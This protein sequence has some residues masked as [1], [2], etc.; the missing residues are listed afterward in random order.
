[1][2]KKNGAQSEASQ[3]HIDLPQLPKGWRWATVG[4]LAEADEQPVLTGPFG[5]TLGRADFI[6]KG[7]PLLT[8]G[9]LTEAGVTLDKAF[10]ISNEKADQLS[11]YRVRKGDL[12]FSR[13]A[14]V[15]RAGLVSESLEGSVINYHLM[16]L[17]LESAII[18]P[19]LFIYYVRGSSVVSAY[20]REV[21]HGATR[22]G[23]NTT[24]LLGMPV[25]V[26]PRDAQDRIV[27]RIEELFSDLEAGV[28]ALTRAR[29]NLKRYR[30]SVLKAAVEGALTAEWRTRHPQVEPAS[31]L[32]ERLL[33]ERRRQWEADQLAKFA[34]AGKQPPNN[35]QAKYAEPSPPDTTN[36]PTLPTGWCWANVEQVTTLVTKGSSPGWQGFD[37]VDA[38]VPFVRSQN[39][40]WGS[41]DLTELVYL[42]P[43]FN[44]SHQNSII[45]EGDVLLNLVGASIGRAAVAPMAMDGANTN[46]AVGIIRL[47]PNS[48]L[49]QLLVHFLLSPL[50]QSHIAKTKADVARANFNLDDVR[51]TPIPLP[52]LAE[53][54]QIVATVSEKLSQIESAEV[55]IEHSLRRAARLRQ[56]IL[57]N[58]FEG[59]I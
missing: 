51:P 7:V 29:G 38:G 4:Q 43:E 36:L 57:K 13:S 20:L 5:S 44:D 26:P 17:R 35:W 6:P 30:A 9:C 10:Y 53:Q 33:T 8:I 56:S 39:I 25:A 11:R 47:A 37:Y 2:S 34:A 46:Q 40:R 52:P 59:R 55:A 32:L 58:A 3:P 54:Q 19:R 22:D 21:N 45:R 49:N 27:G 41:A 31:K 28:A 23:I 24:D 15:G 14:S 1:M 12:L 42:P 18:D 48:I 50:L 16:R